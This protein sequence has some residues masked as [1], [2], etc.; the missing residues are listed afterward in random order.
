M[1]RPTRITSRGPG[2]GSRPMKPAAQLERH[3]PAP[4]LEVDSKSRIGFRFPVIP[5]LV[6]DRQIVPGPD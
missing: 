2:P 5:V 1:S 3:E 6:G 4:K